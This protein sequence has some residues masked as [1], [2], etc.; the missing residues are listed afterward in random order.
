MT[1]LTRAGASK[2]L[3]MFESE[4]LSRAAAVRRDGQQ[5]GC[6]GRKTMTTAPG[7]TSAELVQAWRQ[8]NQQAADQAKKDARTQVA[9]ADAAATAAAFGGGARTGVAAAVAAAAARAAEGDVDESPTTRSG[10][11]SL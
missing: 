6:G 7:A 11:T 3:L 2:A 9:W 10:P 8:R 4:R 5:Q 1:V